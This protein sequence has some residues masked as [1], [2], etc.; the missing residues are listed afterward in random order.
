MHMSTY[1][2]IEQQVKCKNMECFQYLHHFIH[3]HSQ[4]TP[5]S[6]NT[7]KKHVLFQIKDVQLQFY[8]LHP[9]LKHFSWNI[10]KGPIK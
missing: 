6:Y 4:K 7:H 5:C 2:N 1:N 8:V 3:R 9:D 10:S